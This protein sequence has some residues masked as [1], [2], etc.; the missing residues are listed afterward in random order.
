MAAVFAGFVIMGVALGGGWLLQRTPSPLETTLPPRSGG[1]LYARACVAY[2]AGKDDSPNSR[3]LLFIVI[4]KRRY[5]ERQLRRHP[6]HYFKYERFLL[7]RQKARFKSYHP[8]SKGELVPR[9]L[10]RTSERKNA[11]VEFISTCGKTQYPHPLD[12]SA[13]LGWIG[14]S[15]GPIPPKMA[16]SEVFF[17]FVRTHAGEKKLPRR[18]GVI[19]R[20]G[21]E[22]NQRIR[23]FLWDYLDGR[24]DPASS[25][26]CQ[27]NHRIELVG[28]ALQ[29]WAADATQIFAGYAKIEQTI[30]SRP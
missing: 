14:D 25:S 30:Q 3:Q 8:R 10:N 4:E 9:H 24:H 12:F 2:F 20:I 17:P 19:G 18:S 26:A 21:S 28:S 6:F 1:W 13:K 5:E 27:K 7:I 16:S 29:N 22:Q 11:F 23:R 15:G